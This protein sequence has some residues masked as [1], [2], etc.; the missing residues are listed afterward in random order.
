MIK[1]T[2]QQRLA[3]GSLSRKTSTVDNFTQRVD[4]IKQGMDKDLPPRPTSVVMT[5]SHTTDAAPTEDRP[6]MRPRSQ[7]QSAHEVAKLNAIQ[8]SLGNPQSALDRLMANS[9]PGSEGDKVRVVS[10][11]D[12]NSSQPLFMPPG[13]LKPDVEDK[14]RAISGKVEIVVEG[15]AGREKAINAK[16]KEVRETS[17]SGVRRRRSLSVGDTDVEEVVSVAKLVPC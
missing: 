13:I 14:R 4:L 9:K 17:G 3:D 10:S 6:A 8:G 2:I 11:A 7:T 1:E 16:R 15:M 5:K 12:T